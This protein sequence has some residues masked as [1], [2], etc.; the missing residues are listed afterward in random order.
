MQAPNPTTHTLY[1]DGEPCR[2]FDVPLADAELSMEYRNGV[3]N[4]Y[5]NQWLVV[6]SDYLPAD[7][8]YSF[9]PAP[10]IPV[11]EWNGPLTEGDEG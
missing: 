11:R 3:M 1:K 4:V 6:L 2:Q 5:A 7:G 9:E 8:I 10:E